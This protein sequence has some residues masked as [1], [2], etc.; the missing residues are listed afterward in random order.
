[1]FRYSIPKVVTVE[2]EVECSLK[3][4]IC[5][6][7]RKIR[8]EN[9]MTQKQVADKIGM[10]RTNLCNIEKGT[11]NLAIETL[12]GL[13]RAYNCEFNSILPPLS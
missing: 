1:M 4:R 5:Y 2:Q 6:N 8:H 7:M 9:K 12:Y 11:T 10:T 3:E 13:C